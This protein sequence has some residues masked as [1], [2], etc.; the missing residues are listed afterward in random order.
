MTN[1]DYILTSVNPLWIGFVPQGMG[2]I[3]FLSP[4]GYPFGNERL[5]DFYFLS[6]LGIWYPLLLKV[7]GGEYLNPP[8]RR[9]RIFAAF[10]AC[11]RVRVRGGAR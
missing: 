9:D 6:L 1:R 4:F 5:G 8:M 3:L 7:G 10:L 11:V 2:E